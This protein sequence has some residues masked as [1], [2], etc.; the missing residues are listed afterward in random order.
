MTKTR[1]ALSAA[2]LLLAAAAP[3]FAD[4]A[5]DKAVQ[6]V[7]KLGGKVVRDDKDPTKPVVEVDLFLRDKPSEMTDAGLKE[8]AALKGLQKL[9]LGPAMVTDAGLK[10]LAGLKALKSLDLSDCKGVTDVG[11]KDLQQALPDLIIKR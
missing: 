7:E 9:K 1:L 10:E 3:L 6:A 4:D 8:L 5:E 11:V 2:C